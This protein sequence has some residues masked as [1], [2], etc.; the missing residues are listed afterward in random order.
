MLMTCCTYFFCFFITADTTGEFFF[1]FFCAGCFCYDLS[2]IP[3]MFTPIHIYRWHICC[4][5]SVQRCRQCRASFCYSCN[6]SI[7]IGG[8]GRIIYWNSR[9]ICHDRI[10]SKNSKL[11][12][13][14]YFCWFSGSEAIGSFVKRY[15]KTRN[16]AFRH[17]KAHGLLTVI[18]CCFRGINRSSVCKFFYPVMTAIQV[19]MPNSNTIKLRIQHIPSMSLSVIRLAIF[20]PC[21]IYCFC[22]TISHCNVL[23]GCTISDTFFLINTEKAFTVWSSMIEQ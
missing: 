9:Q 17:R 11:S 1:A 13:K 10:A 12:R 7:A 4:C 6:F 18:C 23:S 20:T 21:R 19:N 15:F 5:Q 22:C 8:N 2:L 14:L 16:L 3:M